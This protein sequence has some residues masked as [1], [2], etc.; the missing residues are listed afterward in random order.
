MISISDKIW[1]EKKV[2][3]NLV[4]KIKQDFNLEDIISKLII[5]RKFDSTEIANIDKNLNINNIF[6]NKDDFKYSSEILANA[7][8]NKENICI[9]GDYDVDGAAATSLLVRFFKHINHPHFYYI[10]NREKDGYGATKKLFEKLILNKPKL[11]I[12]V[13]CGST[14]NEAIDFLN[15]KKIQSI[16]IDHHEIRKP[17]PKTSS[18]I[19]PKKNNSYINCDYMCATTLTYFF[20]DILIKK[21][22]S[23]FKLSNFL[24]YVL[25]ATICDVM[26][27][28][29]INKLIAKYVI[30]NFKINNIIAFDILLKQIGI[31]RK[32]TVDDLGYLIG[33]IINAGGRLG[34]ANYG[35]EL[36]SSDDSSLVKKRC[37]QLIELNNKRKK[38]EQNILNEINF[39]K[40]KKDNK[41]VII[42]YKPNINEGVI[43]II[44][45]RLKDYFNKPSIVITSSN[46]TFKGS[47]RSTSNYSIGNL[48]KLLIDKKII[49]KGGGHNMAA[50]FTIKKDN[51][52]FLDKFIQQ[53]YHKKNPQY[54][55]SHEYD[56]EIS[57]SAINYSFMNKINKLGPFGNNNL[58]PIFLIKDIQIIKTKIL[59]DKH[60]SAIIKPKNRSSIRSIC[61]NCMN[62]KIG[63]YILSYKKPINIIAEI[64]ENIWNNKKIIQLN[65][66]DIILKTN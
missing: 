3:K 36:L 47:A 35:V 1:I 13:D 62:N 24:I 30:K 40:I 60:V 56:S 32:I 57:S 54:K 33:P 41:N 42:Y 4:E 45:A 8:K 66:K 7:I 5:S 20:L 34:Y 61:F 18:F 12:M 46:T 58:L 55:I 59:K 15:K 51:I 38:I 19:N 27:L 21:I 65:I 26:P 22:N 39:E 6:K 44:A 48:I 11:M 9:L 63:E 2:N 50:G 14:S 43:G 53:D 23:N 52:K 17:Y 29:K 16:I 10:P 31:N 28:R 25:L 37:I 64:R 49:E